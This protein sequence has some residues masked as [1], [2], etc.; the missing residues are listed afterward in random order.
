MQWVTTS[1]R[2]VEAERVR[3][4]QVIQRFMRANDI[5]IEQIDD[6][7][8]IRQHVGRVEHDQATAFEATRAVLVP[9]AVDDDVLSGPSRR[10]SR[11][12]IALTSV[13]ATGVLTGSLSAHAGVSHAA[14]PSDVPAWDA[15]DG[16]GAAIQGASS[17]GQVLDL[18]TQSP[19]GDLREAALLRDVEALERNAWA[20]PLVAF[21]TPLPL[22]SRSASIVPRGARPLASRMAVT[23]TGYGRWYDRV[24]SWQHADTDAVQAAIGRKAEADRLAAVAAEAERQAAL[25]AEA[26]RV[27]AEQAAYLQWQTE[28][29]AAYE[30]WKLEDAAYGQWLS[31]QQAAYE[32][33]AAGE[34]AQAAAPTRTTAPAAPSP[35][36]S[37]PTT[38]APAPSTTV[39]TPAPLAPAAVP[40]PANNTEALE[41]QAFALI[42]QERAAVGLPAL[43]FNAGLRDAARAQA[44]SIAAAHSLFHQ[45]LYPIL[46]M[47]WTAAAENVGGGPSI[48]TLHAAFVASSGHYANI[49][50][51]RV[52]ALG[53]GVVVGSDGTIW[54]AHVFAG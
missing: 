53:V 30:Q 12:P 36:S 24:S 45:D 14:E 52:T 5:R 26:E 32:Q 42:N 37:A 39:A 38:T 49:T 51:G 7:C 21:G 43:S 47:G 4:N 1:D 8:V 34:A 28:Q 19:D 54:I 27:A 15:I 17:A 3:R 35:S 20:Q 31:E 46:A 2:S 18:L 29:Q 13:V 33:W 9:V 6:D 48:D 10:R 23:A 41:S 40:A 25:Q 22:A 44:G 11:R 50:N 16:A